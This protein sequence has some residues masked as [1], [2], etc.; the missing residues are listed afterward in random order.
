MRI[1]LVFLYLLLSSSLFSQ[2][3]VEVSYTRDSKGN[4]AFSCTNHAFCTYIVSVEFTTFE[5]A[6]ADHALPYLAEVKPGINKLFTVAP[7]NP[8]NDISI[9]YKTSFRKGCFDPKIDTGFA[10]LLPI[11]PGKETQVYEMN[12]TPGEGGRD[13]GCT[14]RLRMK[15]GDT[16]YSAR[17]GIITAVYTGS[18][19]ND[20]GATATDSWNYVEIVHGDCTFGLY[21]VFRKDG[22]FLHPGQTVAAG[23]PLGLV[24]GD[25]FGRGSDVRF[26][27]SYYNDKGQNIQ[28]PLRFW[29]RR[30]GKG[31]LKHGGTYTS[32]HPKALVTQEMPK[33]PAKKAPVRKKG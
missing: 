14:V 31:R 8:S 10:Y 19:E 5:N 23:T 21:G 32:E 2:R 26:S 27:V 25:K 13:S 16:I 17:R 20:A 1:I 3:A 30:N 18:A 6:R 33:P 7:A 29:T 15:Q 4:M 22:A 11:A 9:K 12:K 28:L 24:G